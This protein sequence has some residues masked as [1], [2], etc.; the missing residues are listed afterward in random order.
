[1]LEIGCGDGGNLLPM[2]AALPRSTFVGV[3]LAQ[4]P[5]RRGAALAGE[6]GLDNVQL[7]AADVRD[8]PPDLGEFD[9]VIAHGVYSW[10][11]PDAR[12]ALLAT[13]GRLLAPQGVAYVSYN[14]YPGS[15]VRDMA[16]DAL[17]F[18]VEH[19]SDP[20]QRMAQ[21]RALIDLIARSSDAAAHGRALSDYMRELLARP[22]WLLFHDELSEFNTPV[23]F[24]E[25]AAHAGAHELQ[26]LAEAHLADSQVAGLPEDVAA[27]L[28]ALPDDVVLREQYLD[29]VVNRMF[30]QTLLCRVG[31]PVRRTIEV[32]VLRGLSVAAPLR[33][34]ASPADLAGDERVRFT[35]PGGAYLETADASFKDVLTRLGRAWP[36]AIPFGDL[37]GTTPQRIGEALLGAHAERMVALHVE[38]PAPAARAGER[39][40]AFAPARRQAEA[41]ADLV[42]SLRHES[43]RMDDELA[44]A[45]LARLDGTRDRAALAA[46]LRAQ[47]D[48]LEDA[49]ARLAELSLLAA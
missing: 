27:A 31:I 30:R 36:R 37:A 32:E 25:F 34:D 46:E 12:A 13:C 7:R 3:D 42:T 43:V 38:P 9:Y 14:A 2:A 5:V 29:F 6:L 8:L 21:S 47:P 15:Y 39:P 33:T 18:H 22:D 49:L 20:E 4:E 45:L 24:H 44:R 17:L 1:M 23:Y 41:G 16:R 19:V 40:A 10:I 26:F 28:S 48:R 35:R 11:P